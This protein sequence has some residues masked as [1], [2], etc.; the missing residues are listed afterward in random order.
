MITLTH[1]RALLERALTHTTNPAILHL[2]EGEHRAEGVARAY[3]ARKIEMMSPIGRGGWRAPWSVVGLL[4]ESPDESGDWRLDLTDPGTAPAL[5][6]ALALA[7]GLDPG[8]GGLSVRWVRNTHNG[9]WHLC[10]VGDMATF[11]ET[12]EDPYATG[13]TLRA[14]TVAVEPDPVRALALA[15]A[16]V[17]E[18]AP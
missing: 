5:L 7:L 6:V 15:V 9:D 13:A 17:L 12:D 16:H 10:A 1:L 14:P 8:V 3:L 2:S 4:G 18:A 11:A